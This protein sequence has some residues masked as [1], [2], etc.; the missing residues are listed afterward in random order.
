MK[1]MNV[2]DGLAIIGALIVMVGVFFAAE[3]ALAGS[4]SNPPVEQIRLP[5]RI[6][7]EDEAAR[8]AE[9][10]ERAA[11]S[12]Q[13]A[14]KLDLDIRLGNHTSTVRRGD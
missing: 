14:L 8:Q 12:I 10:A 4:N 9:M 3:D 13:N 5:S 11:E 7:A 2:E 1:K 6:L